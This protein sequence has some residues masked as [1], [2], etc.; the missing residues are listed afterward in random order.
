MKISA[1]ACRIKKE[2][3]Q[4]RH[5]EEQQIQERHHREEQRIKEQAVQRDANSWGR[6][7]AKLGYLGLE[8]TKE[9]KKVAERQQRNK[10]YAR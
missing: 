7:F 6:T 3:E 5:A 2:K 8:D 10:E 9:K 1:S 4:Q